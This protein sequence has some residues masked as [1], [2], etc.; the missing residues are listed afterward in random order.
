MKFYY[1]LILTACLFFGCSKDNADEPSTNKPSGSLNSQNYNWALEFSEFST[2][3]DGWRFPVSD[4]Y[5]VNWKEEHKEYFN[6]F[7]EENNGYYIVSSLWAT[8]RKQSTF[9]Q[10]NLE[11][12]DFASCSTYDQV[13]SD[14]SDPMG[15]DIYSCYASNTDLG[16]YIYFTANPSISDVKSLQATFKV[17]QNDAGL[18]DGLLEWESNNKEN[19]SNEDT[20]N[21]I[22]TKTWVFNIQSL[23]NDYVVNNILPFVKFTEHE[24]DEYGQIV[25]T[26]LS[27]IV[28]VNRQGSRVVQ[29]FGDDIPF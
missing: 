2:Y 1:T 9:N 13:G 22:I 7:I 5:I 8:I 19:F 12:Y 21:G 20:I 25:S 10:I 6:E 17:V 27:C 18:P 14:P 15:L 11:G 23:D 28:T 16:Y 3:E 4:E 26:R 29:V 24:F